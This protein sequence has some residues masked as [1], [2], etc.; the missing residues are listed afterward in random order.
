[1]NVPS[2]ITAEQIAQVE[3]SMVDR[4]GAIFCTFGDQQVSFASYKDLREWLGEARR[5]IALQ[6]PAATGGSGSTTRYA[7]TRKGV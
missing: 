2:S 6:D 7:A 5:L 4:N 3:Q 1:M